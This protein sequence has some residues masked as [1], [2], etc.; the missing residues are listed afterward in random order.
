MAKQ[1]TMTAQQVVLKLHKPI[2]V[3]DDDLDRHNYFAR[4][5]GSCFDSVYSAEN[6]L[7]NIRAGALE[8]VA[9]F[10]DRDLGSGMNGNE[11]VD[12]LKNEHLEMPASIKHIYI[13]SNNIP[14]A[15]RMEADLKQ[16]YPNLHIEQVA[17]SRLNDLSVEVGRNQE[18][19]RKLF[20]GD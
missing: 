4:L 8:S 15:I 11:F 16:I 2:L 7:S 14:A 5:F 18:A 6:L 17:T 19:L 9:L 12:T 1:S 20:I 10:L 3:L 13:H